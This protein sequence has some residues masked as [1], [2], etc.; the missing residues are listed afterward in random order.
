VP[1]G[2]VVLGDELRLTQ[3]FN[4]LIDNAAKFTRSGEIR[5][6]CQLRGDNIVLSV[7][8]TGVG[9]APS[10]VNS[11]FDRFFQAENNRELSKRGLGLGLAICKNIIEAHE[12]EIWARS[13]VG[14]GTTIYVRLPL[15]VP[16]EGTRDILEEMGLVLYPVG[17]RTDST[18]ESIT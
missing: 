13:E 14:M 18:P 16:P 15:A 4:N 8:D 3:V 7:A 5:L 10:Q 9:I 1:A 2:L 11:I 12:G 6:D 17:T